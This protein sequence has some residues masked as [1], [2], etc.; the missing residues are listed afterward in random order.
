MGATGEL[1]L[2]VALGQ[3]IEWHALHLHGEDNHGALVDTFRTD[4]NLAVARLDDAPTY[5][6][7]KPDAFLVEL[8]RVVQLTESNEQALYVLRS[9]ALSRVV[10]LHDQ[11][12]IEVVERVNYFDQALV[13]V[14]QGVFDQVDEDLLEPDFVALETLKRYFLPRGHVSYILDSFIFDFRLFEWSLQE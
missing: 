6:Q 14:L 10:D 8:V 5:R 1:L 9:D 11:H 13:C 4:L 3:L 2:R 12:V 7:A